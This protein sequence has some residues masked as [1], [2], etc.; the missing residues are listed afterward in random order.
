[1]HYCEVAITAQGGFC[2]E[3]AVFEYEGLAPPEKPK[4][5]FQ[6]Y[7]IILKL[8][9]EHG[10]ALAIEMDGYATRR[11]PDEYVTIRRIGNTVVWFACKS[12]GQH[13]KIEYVNGP[14]VVSKGL[15]EYCPTCGAQGQCATPDIEKDYWDLLSQAF[16]NM[17]VKLLRLLY[18]SWLQQDEGHRRFRDYI[19][20][21]LA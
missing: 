20:A 4:Y 16:D 12:C 9:L 18:E 6:K 17:E 14:P 15:P 2:R 19:E 11:L 10:R 8:C 21:Q 7:Q 13:L 5:D 3:T 1:M